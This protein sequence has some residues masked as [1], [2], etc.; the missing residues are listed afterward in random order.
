MVAA[1]MLLDV[2]DVDDVAEQ[3]APRIRAAAGR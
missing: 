1:R 2:A 3:L